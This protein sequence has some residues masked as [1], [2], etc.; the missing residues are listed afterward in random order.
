V[1]F[2]EGIGSGVVLV[3]HGMKDLFEIQ[4]RHVECQ[5]GL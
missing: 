4:A 5:Y 2:A 3:L 1:S